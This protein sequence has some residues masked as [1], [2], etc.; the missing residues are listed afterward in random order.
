VDSVEAR[1]LVRQYLSGR[2]EMDTLILGCTHYPLLRDVL[3]DAVGPSVAL[4][5]SAEA[6]AEVVSEAFEGAPHGDAPGRVV[7]FV[8]AIRWRSRTPPR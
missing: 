3:Q 1:L 8:T 6:T 2:P 4:V 7:H 5:D